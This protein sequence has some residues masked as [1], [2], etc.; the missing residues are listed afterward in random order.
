MLSAYKQKLS[1]IR[2]KIREMGLQS[3]VDVALFAIITLGLH[4]LWWNW[5]WK[6]E[7]TG[8]LKLWADV[9]AHWVYLSSS[10]SLEH[11]FGFIHNGH[12]DT[13]FFNG[14]WIQIVPSCSGLKQFYQLFFLLLIFPGPWK[15]KLW[16]IPAGMI[17]IFFVNVFRIVSLTYIMVW[18]PQHWDFA[19]L[20]ILRPF[21]YV[22]IFVLWMVW[23][24]KFW[25]R[26]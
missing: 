21:Y 3:V 16:Y 7:T 22:V 12:N 6:W 14:T 20:W 9:L 5:L 15:H 17:L 11:I 24:E 18:W 23:V 2:Q 10:W 8:F 1:D 26:G 25:R 4:L 19:H 13:L